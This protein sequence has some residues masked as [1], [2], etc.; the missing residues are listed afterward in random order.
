LNAEQNKAVVRAIVDCLNER[1][2]DRLAT[3]LDPTYTDHGNGTTDPGGAEA[4]RDEFEDWFASFPDH[5]ITIESLVAETDFVAIRTQAEAT[6][7]GSFRGLPAT[8]R[9]VVFGAQELYRL[10]NGRAVEHWEIWD[11]AALLRQLSL[12]DDPPGSD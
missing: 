9:R 8:G 10:R 3:L 5:Q 11:E 7:S 2:F 4:L 6:H 1:A 12:L